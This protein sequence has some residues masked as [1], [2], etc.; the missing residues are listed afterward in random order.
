MK[1]SP[2]ENDTLSA[3]YYDEHY[4]VGRD[5]LFQLLRSRG[6]ET[7]SRRKVA[8]WLKQQEISQLYQPTKKNK[9]I[10]PTVLNHPFKQ[11]GIDL[12]DFQHYEYKGYKYILT[13]VDLFSKMTYAIPLQDK[14]GGTV[15]KAFRKLFRNQIKHKISSVRSD[16]GSEFVDSKFKRVLNSLD[17]T[18]VFS[19]PHKPQSNGN[20]ERVNGILK[21]LL[22]M[23]MKKTGKKDWVSILPKMIDNYNHTIHKTT[24]KTPI[25]CQEEWLKNNKDATKATKANIEKAVF[26]NKEVDYRVLKKG[27]RVRLRLGELDKKKYQQN[28]TTKIFKI[29]K[30]HKP[31]SKVSTIYYSISGKNKRFYNNDLLPISHRLEG[32]IARTEEDEVSGI[33]SPGIDEDGVA[34][35]KVRWKHKRKRSDITFQTRDRLIQDIPKMLGAFERSKGIKWIKK[36][37]K[38]VEMKKR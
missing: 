31:R 13:G 15:A 25:Q 34:W 38:Y 12:M 26:K 14:E 33:F 1:I 21:R 24:K 19:L 30:V 17:I 11:V 20:I 2:K 22:F 5:K 32:R 9:T 29:T 3:I 4:Y 6:I 27:Q 18:Q 10:Q 8:Q 7:I 36:G 16:R 23:Y 35:Y 28:W 37:L